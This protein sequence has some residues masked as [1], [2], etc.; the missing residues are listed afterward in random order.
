MGARWEDP[1]RPLRWLPSVV[2]PS[3]DRLQKLTVCM[4]CL[5][6]AVRA[7]RM[8]DQQWQVYGCQLFLSALDHV[9][10]TC[11]NPVRF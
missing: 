7:V 8:G 1:P 2:Q 10:A 5:E 11:T 3:E 9:E 4:T 6:L